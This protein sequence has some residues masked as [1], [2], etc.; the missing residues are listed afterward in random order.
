MFPLIAQLR[1]PTLR[2]LPKLQQFASPLLVRSTHKLINYPLKYSRVNGIYLASLLLIISYCTSAES[3]SS[4]S[5]E[6]PNGFT[7]A[8]ED[9]LSSD[10]VVYDLQQRQNRGKAWN[11]YHASEWIPQAI[12]FP[13]STQQVSDILRICHRFKVPIVPFGGGTSVEGH[14]LVM[15]PGGIS[16]D[17]SRMKKIL[18]FHETDLDI[19][20]EAGLGY[21]ELNDLIRSKGLWFPLDPGRSPLF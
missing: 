9:L 19:T 20:V 14:T 4:K 1:H 5:E 6:L 17:F 16:L 21:L 13:E 8:L 10:Q 3:E 12:I 11:S 7:D 18:A 2:S 15:Q